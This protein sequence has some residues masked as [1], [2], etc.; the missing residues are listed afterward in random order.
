MLDLE[1]AQAFLSVV[2][3]IDIDNDKP[4]DRTGYDADIRLRPAQE[5][6]FDVGFL[7]RRSL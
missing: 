4:R 5:P 7:R 3:R 1:P 6:V 2:L